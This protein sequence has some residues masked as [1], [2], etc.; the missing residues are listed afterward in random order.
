MNVQIAHGLPQEWEK[1]A[2][3]FSA[4]GDNTRQ[5]ILLVFEQDEEICVNEIC[6]MFRLSRSAICHHLKVL[7]EAK[8]LCCERRGKEV[9]YWVNYDYCAEVLHTVHKF[10]S[11]KT[12]SRMPTESDPVG[13]ALPHAAAADV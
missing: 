7:R 10:V 6:R 13:P 8:L 3:F 1:F 12:E 2:Q 5:Q 4:L 9:Y 11:A